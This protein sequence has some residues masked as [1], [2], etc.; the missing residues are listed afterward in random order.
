MLGTFNF[1]RDAAPTTRLHTGSVNP[2]EE[3]SMTGG[4]GSNKVCQRFWL[5]FWITVFFAAA[6]RADAEHYNRETPVV[7][8][9]R[10]VSPAV[11]NI[12]S[13]IQVRQAQNPFSG[14]APPHL[15]WFF[16]DFFDPG[17]ERRYRTT[18]LGSGVIIDG[19][20][21]FILT[22]AHVVAR[23]GAITVTLMDE[24]Q[25]EAQLVGSDPDSDLAVLRIDADQPLP[26][27][28]MGCCDDLMIGETVIA[29]GNPFGFS[30]TVTTGVI[31]ALNRSF[32]ADDREYYD[33]IQIDASINPGNSG[34]PLLNINGALIGINTAI[35][36]KAQGIGFAIPIDRAQRIV[37]DLINFGEVIQAWI[38]L[39]VQELDPRLAAY[40]G[41][42]DSDGVL[43]RAVEEDSPAT[44]G[45]IA[46][47]DVI[48]AM[49]GNRIADTEAYRRAAAAVAPR[50]TLSVEVWRE[51]RVLKKTVR[52][53]VYP[54][55]KTAR[56][57]E[58]LLGI[59]VSDIT[60]D[61]RRRYRLAVSSGVVI[62]SVATD[63]FLAQTGV[64]PGDVIRQ[65]G[66]DP[67]KDRRDF[68]K[69]LVKQ[70]HQN[71]VVL[72]VQRGRQGYYITVELY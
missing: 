53:S 68:E 50:Q 64:E 48:R 43:V 55:E 44:K 9:V 47:G 38:G 41:L 27:V 24:R 8:A 12:S 26:A 37:N 25:F 7:K 45:G 54:P 21:G 71:A 4:I 33:F 46:A 1:I 34:G 14:M 49:D 51:G 62:T 52:T 28:A 57:A 15:E 59:T 10:A 58:A 67:V 66:D 65:V 19:E 60:P 5:A 17:W 39:R 70:R 56:L 32:R 3:E 30:H 2:P 23:A 16:K 6:P 22:N 69:A 20:R 13:Q 72:L 18:S 31:S 11:V 61:L 40:L 36:A 42:P 63:T 35:Y 29:I